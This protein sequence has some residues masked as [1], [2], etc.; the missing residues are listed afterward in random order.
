MG[1]NFIGKDWRAKRDLSATEISK[2]FAIY[3]VD[4]EYLYKTEDNNN[5]AFDRIQ[6][7]DIAGDINT[8]V[9]QIPTF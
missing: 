5:I 4:C 1:Q 6:C 7:T 2:D 8:P 9:A 3:I